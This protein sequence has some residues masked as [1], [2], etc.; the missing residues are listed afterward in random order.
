MLV[1]ANETGHRIS[2]LAQLRWSDV[3]LTRQRILWRGEHD[4]IGFEHET[5]LTA[6]AVAALEKTRAQEMKIGD[7]WVFPAPTDPTKHCS[8]HLFR[9]WWQ[10]AE[11]LAGLSHV[12]GRGYHSLWRKFATEMKNTP[13]KDLCHLGGWKDSNTILKCY[14][15]ADEKT[16]RNALSHRKRLTAAGG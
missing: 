7:A 13:L 12:R 3:D 9:D 15:Q 10:S 11:K 16:M 6:E 2:A 8:R 4:K 1:L 14:Q 5:P